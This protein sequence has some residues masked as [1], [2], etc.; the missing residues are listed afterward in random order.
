MSTNQAIRPAGCKKM[1]LRKRKYCAQKA[2][3]STRS[4][5]DHPVR[6]W[7]WVKQHARNK[8]YRLYYWRRDVNKKDGNE[9]WVFKSRHGWERVFLATPDIEWTQL[10]VD[11]KSGTK[12]GTLVEPDAADTKRT[13]FKVEV[14]ACMQMGR[15][16]FTRAWRT[17]KQA[18]ATCPVPKEGQPRCGATVEYGPFCNECLKTQ[19]GVEV[20]PSTI[21]GAGNGVFLTRDI[22][23]PGFVVFPYGGELV[24]A[25]TDKRRYDPAWVQ[26]KELHPNPAVLPAVRSY[27]LG[28]MGMKIFLD[29]THVRGIGSMI[30]CSTAEHPANVEFTQWDPS[31]QCRDRAAG[32]M[33]PEERCMVWVGLMKPLKAGT[34]LFVDYRWKRKGF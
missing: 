5:R 34:E 18:A 10:T 28:V 21:P 1:P 33:L 27:T 22:K 6:G 17:E 25:V 11:V 30:N 12:R 29:A 16:D 19:Y 24:S 2:A 26:A 32:I 23:K 9:V 14:D 13:R 3:A 20:R 31:E 4:R 15:P 7:C 8:T